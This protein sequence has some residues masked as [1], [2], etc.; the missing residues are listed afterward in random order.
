MRITILLKKKLQEGP[1]KHPSNWAPQFLRPA[2]F[3]TIPIWSDLT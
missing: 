2:L 1:R 3:E